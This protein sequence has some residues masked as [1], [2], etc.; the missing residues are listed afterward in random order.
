MPV[1][2]VRLWLSGVSGIRNVFIIQHED[3]SQLMQPLPHPPGKEER[4]GTAYEGEF[5]GYLGTYVDLPTGFPT[6]NQQ[7]QLRLADPSIPKPILKLIRQNFP[8]QS[9]AR[10]TVTSR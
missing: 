7:A 2:R 3:G 9:I 10:E 1:A 8:L 6:T 5:C 4:V